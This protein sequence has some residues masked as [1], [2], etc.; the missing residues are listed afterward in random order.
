MSEFFALDKPN[1]DSIDTQKIVNMLFKQDGQQLRNFVD[2]SNEPEY[3]YWDKIKYKQPL[4]NELGNKEAWHAVKIVRQI[5][6]MNTAIKN[7]KNQPFT[8]VK[9]PE[10]EKFYHEVDMNTG[11]ALFILK[12]DFDKAT[13]QKLISRG[14]MEEAIASSQLEG[15]STSRKIAKQFLREGRKPR[16]ESERMILNN[17]LSMKALEESYK[18]QRMSLD[19]LFELH[20]MITKDTLTAEEEV[21]RLREDGEE[22]FVVDKSNGIIYHK[23]PDMNFV[24][25]ELERL[26]KFANDELD[27]SFIHPIIKAAMLHFWLGYLHPFTDGNGRLARLLFYWY[28]LKNGYWAFAYLPI[29]KIIKKSPAQY[30]MAYILSEQDENDLTYFIDYNIRKIKLAV[31]EFREYLQG[32]TSAN[33]GMNR[34]AQTKYDLND[35][36]I[37]LLQHL[38][39]DPEERTSLKTHMSIFQIANKTAIS[40]LKKLVGL[41]F[42]ESKKTGRNIYYYPTY[43]VAEL[44]K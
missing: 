26:V 37:Q 36:Q 34:V 1:L 43:K 2:G 16:N 23:G 25:Q 18:N 32:Q 17:Y 11:G 29:S 14:V 5:K 13:K 8:W 6:S 10:L 30:S 42:L 4:P 22:I 19:L 24:K 38:H 33:K 27:D 40:D 21:P 12:T 41:H 39:G 31:K 28:L 35:R 7:E 9:L 44:F 3:L 20:G 15:A